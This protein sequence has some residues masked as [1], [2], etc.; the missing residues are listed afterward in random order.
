MAERER[1]AIE[2]EVHELP[3]VHVPEPVTLATTHHQIDAK[4]VE[5]GDTSGNH[6][7]ECSAK[8]LRLLGRAAVRNSV[9]KLYGS[10]HDGLLDRDGGV[11]GRE[12][13]GTAANAVS[14]SSLSL[15]RMTLPVLVVGS[16]VTN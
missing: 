15:R 13:S 4:F 16:S 5:A 14:S 7:V 10:I 3:P 12:P 9:V 11:C 6:I 2:V 8:H 1:A